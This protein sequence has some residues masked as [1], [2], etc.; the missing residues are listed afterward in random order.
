M[1]L[2]VDS[3]ALSF[4]SVAYS[5]P[6]I[7]INR[8]YR[9]CPNGWF[10][11][12]THNTY[13]VSWKGWKKGENCW[14]FVTGETRAVAEIALRVVQLPA[15][16][17]SE[18]GEVTPHVGHTTGEMKL[19]ITMRKLINLWGKYCRISDKP[20]CYVLMG[21]RMHKNKFQTNPPGPLC[22][23]TKSAAGLWVE[24]SSFERNP[25]KSSI[26]I[27]RMFFFQIAEWRRDIQFS[28]CTLLP[29]GTDTL[30]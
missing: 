23:E 21:T 2:S 25:H 9:P 15:S 27:R 20:T 12:F 5:S 26:F 7:L 18:N 17:A 13:N 19:M 4:V 16:G 22:R 8:L 24:A 6:W 1:K 29:E 28:L 10:H 3:P 30:K 14:T 11:Y